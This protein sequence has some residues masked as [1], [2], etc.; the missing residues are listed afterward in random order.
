LTL[1]ISPQ[2]L[3]LPAIGCASGAGWRVALARPPSALPQ[4]NAGRAQAL[5]DGRQA[6]GLPA[7]ALTPVCFFNHALNSPDNLFFPY[8]LRSRMAGGFAVNPDFIGKPVNSRTVTVFVTLW[9]C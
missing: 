6:G 3:D 9:S 5:S 8:I 7:Y 2:V 1:L 4:A